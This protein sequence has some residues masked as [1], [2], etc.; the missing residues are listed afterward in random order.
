MTLLNTFRM[1]PATAALLDE[2][3]TVYVVERDEPDRITFYSETGLRL[4]VHGAADL[5]RAA[6][7]ARAQRRRSSEMPNPWVRRSPIPPPNGADPDQI[8][9][10]EAEIKRLRERGRAAVRQRD[11][12]EARALAAEARLADFGATGASDP[13]YVAIKK[14]LARELHPDG[15]QTDGFEKIIR[16]ALFKRIWPLVEKIDGG[17]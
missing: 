3:L 9:E 15:V 14:M 1:M 6:A 5:E 17:G 10:L 7:Q 4:F 12:W 11:A 13:R 2:V 16:E 8:A